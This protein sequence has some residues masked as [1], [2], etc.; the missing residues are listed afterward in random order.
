MLSDDT[1]LFAGLFEW[2][3]IARIGQMERVSLFVQGKEG[4]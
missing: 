3:G 4:V 1:F 2:T